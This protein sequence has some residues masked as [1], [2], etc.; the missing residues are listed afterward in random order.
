MIA[1]LLRTAQESPDEMR[2]GL[3]ESRSDCHA[4]GAH[5]IY[6]LHAHVLG[7]QSSAQFFGAVRIAPQPGGLKRLRTVTPSP[8]GDIRCELDFEGGEVRGRVTLPAGLP[9][10]FAYGQTKRSLVPGENALP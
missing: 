7:L 4:W 1:A 9:G 10:E 8:K 3:A 2:Y 6:H 5:P